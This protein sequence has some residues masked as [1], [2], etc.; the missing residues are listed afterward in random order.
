M[1]LN[2][3]DS[4]DPTRYNHLFPRFGNYHAKALEAATLARGAANYE[5]FYIAFPPQPDEQLAARGN[6]T[7]RFSVTPN[8]YILGFAAYSQQAAGFKL[9][10]TDLGTNDPFFSKP[11]DYRNVTGQ[12]GGVPANRVFYLPKPRLILE[13]GLLSAQLTNL[14]IVANTVQLV[15]YTVSERYWRPAA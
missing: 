2:V 11:V 8:T 10:L 13:P 9:Q 5:G 4:L 7:G 14:A 1:R 3:F 15:L 12:G 6:W